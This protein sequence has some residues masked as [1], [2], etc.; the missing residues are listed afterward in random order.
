M[1]TALSITDFVLIDRLD[2]E[3]QNG[4]TCLTGETGAGKSI[5]LDAIGC[6]LGMRPSKRFVR[7]GAEKAVVCAEFDLPPDHLVW[8]ILRAEGCAV[9]EEETLLLKR[10][11]PARGGARGY[12]NGQAVP[13]ALLQKVGEHL[14]EI[15]GQHAASHV[16]K[17][18]Y[19]R[20]LLDQ[21]A[22]NDALLAAYQKAL[23]QYKS[24]REVHQTL[25]TSIQE[26][27]AEKD[28][29]GYM[30]EEL[31]QLDPKP[32]E[33]DALAHERQQ[34]MQA[35]RIHETLNAS[36]SGLQHGDIENLLANIVAKLERLMGLPGLDGEGR[37][38]QALQA[39]FQAFERASIET[40]E[41]RANLQAFADLVPSDE[42][43]LDE[44]EARLFALRAA[45]RKYQITPDELPEKYAR[46][47]RELALLEA[48]DEE[49]ETVRQQEQ[50]AAA[51][52]RTAGEALYQ[53]RLAAAARMQT[54]I[55][56]ELQPLKLG[57][58]KV[59]IHVCALP[60]DMSVSNTA[61]AVSFQ[62]QTNA[63]TE[64]GPLQKIASGG[65]LARFSLAVKC[66][67]AE[68][69][70]GQPTLIFDEADQGVG[71]AVA[72]AIGQRLKQLSRHRQVF[73][74]THSPQVAAASQTQ[75]R[76]EK[77]SAGSRAGSGLEPV[78]QAYSDTRTGADTD[79][80]IGHKTHVRI[81]DEDMRL[82]EIARMLAGSQITPEARAAAGRL[83]E[84]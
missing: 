67:L 45:A 59:H 84:G 83:L 25:S 64:F 24:A 29:L 6:T 5:I 11:I 2:L 77:A 68:I 16:L 79:T 71:G 43:Q 53:S 4:F 38:P 65:E 15:H 72:A 70:A 69:Y 54:A 61:E 47:K 58:V 36:M 31:E 23:T 30:A 22:G 17:P 26:A 1:I 10:I 42:G 82:E 20:H 48:G 55:E 13:G 37:L 18:E 51:L 75:W 46:I 66:V 44:L 12:V 62:V 56:A 76:V 28:L 74:V 3:I 32:G 9:S 57:A 14:V 50:A 34:L 39:S 7:S 80:G 21:F 40:E 35:E 41:A 27:A 49:L 8:D 60:E 78:T 33:A 19:Q 81:L 73:A 63:N 52:W